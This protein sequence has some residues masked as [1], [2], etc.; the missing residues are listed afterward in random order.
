MHSSLRIPLPLVPASCLIGVGSC[1]Q[2]GG[3]L[4]SRPI[5]TVTSWGDPAATSLSAV[6]P[7]DGSFSLYPVLHTSDHFD[8][9]F[10]AGFGGIE[11]WSSLFCPF[12][13]Y[14]PLL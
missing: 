2:G 3:G 8:Y 4:A 13:W 1:L 7:L 6:V 12:G 14:L 9:L 11:A 10:I 5:G